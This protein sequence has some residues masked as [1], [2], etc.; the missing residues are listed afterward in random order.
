MLNAPRFL[1]HLRVEVVP[2]EG[3]FVVSGTQ[4]TLLKGRLYELV[5]PWVGDGRTPDDLC[6]RLRDRA[7]AAEVYF[8]LGQLETKGYLCEQAGSLPDE[9]AA[10]WSS[11]Q[12]DPAEAARRL[13]ETTVTLR[14]FGLDAAPLAALLESSRVRPGDEG[15]LSLVVADGYLR[16]ELKECNFEALRSSRPWLLVKPIGRELW[17]GPLFVPGVTGCWACL[18]DRLRA[19]R[20]VES[21]LAGRNG[22]VGAAAV[23]RASS[24][25]T[26]QVAWGLAAQAVAT[27]VARGE[28]PA[29]Q[30]KIQSFDMSTWELKSHTLVRLPYCPACGRPGE[31]DGTTARPMDLGRRPKSFTRD[32][33]HRVVAPEVTLKRFGHHVSPITGAVSMLERVGQDGDGDGDGDGVQHTYIAGHNLARG[34]RDLHHLRSDLRNMSSGKGAT[35]V[36]ARASGL[37]EGLER[38]SGVYRG[39]EPRRRA[40]MA[41]LGMAAVHPH[42]CLLFSSRQYRI[43]DDWNARASRYNFVPV[44]FDPDAEVD[45]TPAWSLTRREPRLLPT[46]FCYYNVPQRGREPF[47]V[48]DSNG[49]AAGNTLEEAILQGFLELVERDAVA[50]WWYNRVRR[51]G[52]D[53]DAFADPYFGRLR[54]HLDGRGRELWAI[55]LTS[56]LGVPVFAAVSRRVEGP[57]E[58]IFLGFGAHLDPRVALLRA[59]T[60]MS[61]MMSGLSDDD[62]DPRHEPLDDPETIHWLRTATV[63]NQPYLLP[64]GSPPRRESD[65]PKDWADDVTEDVRACQALVERHGMELMTLDQTRPEIGLPVAKVIVPGLRHFWA[66]FAPGR[67]FDVPARLGWVAA[68][69]AEEDLNPIPMFL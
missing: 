16:D 62:G 61:Q 68:P 43:R 9:E 46:A 23:D 63:A 17:L 12:V 67:L 56:D 53:L 3:A 30:G 28:L 22:A 29:L 55:D 64:D 13:G 45:W 27:W 7:S 32:G 21:Y 5:V 39:D 41:D 6:D 47:C 58:R 4:Q 54:D 15:A 18:A 48:A 49:N 33:G 11:Q 38:Y 8:V 37:C 19:N 40:R 24:P 69:V 2:G 66:R 14:A 34:H 60:E 20:P 51:P 1:P 65:Y 35:D 57:A 52:V 44:P 42:D 59:V 31:S 26:L 25:A 36:Q 10:L 50:L